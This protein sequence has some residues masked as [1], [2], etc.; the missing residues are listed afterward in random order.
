[1]ELKYISPLFSM[2][3]LREVKSNSCDPSSSLSRNLRLVLFRFLITLA[4]AVI[5][6]ANEDDLPGAD[7][8]DETSSYAFIPVLFY[9]DADKSTIPRSN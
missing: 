4:L 9:K 2:L 1:M 7:S 5:R 6:S 8:F 3:V